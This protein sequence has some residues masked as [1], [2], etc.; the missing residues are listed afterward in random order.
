MLLSKLICFKN[1]IE[2]KVKY[3]FTTFYPKQKH[4]YTLI[5]V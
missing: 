1:I 2:L 4:L 5:M 3:T